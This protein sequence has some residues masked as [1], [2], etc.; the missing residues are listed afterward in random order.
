MPHGLD[1]KGSRALGFPIRQVHELTLN[2]IKVSEVEELGDT[3]LRYVEFQKLNRYGGHAV[4]LAHFTAS[5]K[6]L[7]W[8]DILSKWR[9]N[10]SS[11]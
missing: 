5:M 6:R 4:Y 8:R 7:T 1:E 11:T 3:R 9:K 2:L 10:G